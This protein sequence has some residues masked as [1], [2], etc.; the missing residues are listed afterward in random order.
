MFRVVV[1]LLGGAAAGLSIATAALYL[2]EWRRDRRCLFFSV[3]LTRLGMIG[4]TLFGMGAVIARVGDPILTW[5][6]PVAFICYLLVI[7][8]QVG[9]LWDNEVTRF[10]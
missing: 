9:I 10:R 4:L 5:R 7:V 1:F 8:G 6:A 2:R 3:F